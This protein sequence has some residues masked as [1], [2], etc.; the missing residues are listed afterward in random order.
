MIFHVKQSLVRSNKPAT[1]TER[2]YAYFAQHVMHRV[3]NH[4]SR[5]CGGIVKKYWLKNFLFPFTYNAAARVMVT[6]ERQTTASILVHR[7]SDAYFRDD[8]SLRY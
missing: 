7:V 8:Y 6:Q 3:L 1:I 2:M 5:I 4:K